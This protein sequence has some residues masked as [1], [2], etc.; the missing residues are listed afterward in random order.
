MRITEQQKAVLQVLADMGLLSAA[1]VAPN[2]LKILHYREKGKRRRKTHDINNRILTDLVKKDLVFIHGRGKKRCVGL[3]VTGRR[4]LELAFYNSKNTSRSKGWTMII[5]DITEK[6]RIKRDYLRKDLQ[7]L[8]FKKVQHS[9]WISPYQDKEIA[10]L[11]RAKYKLGK[12]LV[13][14]RLKDIEGEA[15]LKRWFE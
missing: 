8:G 5:Y 12:E 7:R 4:Q 11:L 15:Y 2:V 14:M 6:E 3:T 9:V 13:I 1:L 10:A